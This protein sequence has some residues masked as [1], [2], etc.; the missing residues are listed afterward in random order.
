MPAA[1]LSQSSAH[2]WWRENNLP[3]VGARA[4]SLSQNGRP[5]PPSLFTARVDR[6]L[7]TTRPVGALRFPKPLPPPRTSSRTCTRRR[8]SLSTL[9]GS[10]NS[11]APTPLLSPTPL[12]TAEFSAG[13]SHRALA[14]AH[15]FPDSRPL[16]RCRQH[17]L[18][19]ALAL[20]VLAARSHSAR[21]L[22]ALGN[23]R[24]PRACVPTRLS[25]PGNRFA[26]AFPTP[27][28]PLE[29][30]VSA[31]CLGR[32]RSNLALVFLAA[33]RPCKHLV[34]FP[35]VWSC[36]LGTYNQF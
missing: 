29:R 20:H 5:S 35:A 31:S 36:V 21:A 30:S 28:L 2:P 33:R 12:T 15:S 25:V 16:S 23:P 9:P 4:L 8:P 34:A 13:P 17:R 32:P 22:V 14:P 10:G 18:G 6:F 26:H 24:N 27:V 11:L 1:N 7:A 19:I 3:G